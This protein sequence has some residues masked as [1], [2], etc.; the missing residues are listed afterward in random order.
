MLEEGEGGISSP[1]FASSKRSSA[2]FL[3]ELPSSPIFL[4]QLSYQPKQ[5][6]RGRV[7]LF[8]AFASGLVSTSTF[9]YS[10]SKGV[11]PFKE[12]WELI[13]PLTPV[14][15]SPSLLKGLSCHFPESECK[16]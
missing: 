15:R 9:P 2:A 12:R 13:A 3:G 16:S 11:V 1:G 14:A 6:S 8:L 4:L 5:P 10:A 7:L